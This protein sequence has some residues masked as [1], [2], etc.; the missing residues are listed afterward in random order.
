MQRDRAG[1]VSRS[2]RAPELAAVHQRSLLVRLL[3]HAAAHGA[4]V[5]ADGAAAKCWAL[6]C[7]ASTC[8]KSPVGVALLILLV[9]RQNQGCEHMKSAPEQRSCPWGVG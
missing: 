3:A 5:A 9:L 7:G 2:R 1:G 8:G 6:C 4:A